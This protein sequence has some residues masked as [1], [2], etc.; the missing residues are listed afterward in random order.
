MCRRSLELCNTLSAKMRQGAPSSG[1][2]NA[3]LRTGTEHLELRL[4]SLGAGAV[5]SRRQ[6]ATYCRTGGVDN[7][8]E[9]WID[10]RVA[11]VGIDGIELYTVV[12]GDVW[13][14]SPLL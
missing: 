6:R 4:R 10:C 14:G 11:V 9:G 13:I 12:L 3:V 2:S 5:H 7:T 1:A 8:P